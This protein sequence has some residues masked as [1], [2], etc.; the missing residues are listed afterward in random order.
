MSIFI[1]IGRCEQEFYLLKFAGGG[2]EKEP[3]VNFHFFSGNGNGWGEGGG[4]LGSGLGRYRSFKFL[5]I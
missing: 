3:T 5:I 2:K 4:E 1:T